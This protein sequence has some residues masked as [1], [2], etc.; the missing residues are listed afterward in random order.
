DELSTLQTRFTNE[1]RVAYEDAL[2][3]L[4]KKPLETDEAFS[5]RVTQVVSDSLVHIH[6]YREPDN[7][8]FHQLIPIWENYFLYFMGKFS[9]IPEFEKYHY[10]DY[11]RSI[12]RGVGICGDAS[13][14]MS[15]I[16]DEY[17]IKNQIIS[18]PE[19]VVVAAQTSANQTLIYDPDYGVALPYTLNEIREQPALITDWYYQ[20]G[21]R[22]ADVD[23]LQKIYQKPF[24][25]WNGVQHFFTKKYY[26]EKIAY[27]LKWPLPIVLI[28]LG[29]FLMKRKSR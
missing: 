6:W 9:G 16:L 21:H 29:F 3:Q 25:E 4:Q 5:Q 7:N 22:K 17:S 23:L 20:A 26:F 18:F 1:K 12:K 15:Q 24:K 28:V 8:R 2:K 19:H 11:Q 13:M 27:A 10:T 14:V